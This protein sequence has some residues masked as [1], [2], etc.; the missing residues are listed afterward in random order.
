MATACMAYERIMNQ[1]TKNASTPQLP[2]TL[3]AQRI[4]ATAVGGLV[5]IVFGYLIWPRAREVDVARALRTC[6]G[7][8]GDFLTQAA[9]P[10]PDDPAE[11]DARHTKLVDARRLTYASLS[12]LR[13]QLQRGLA[14]PPPAYDQAVRWT[15]AV[16]DINALASLSSPEKLTQQTG[17]LRERL[18]QPVLQ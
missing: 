8:L 10:I 9:T 15:P 18:R 14:E 17:A 3:P 16:A 5:V 2:S 1:G 12:D 7:T 13:T 4:L 11:R 6:V